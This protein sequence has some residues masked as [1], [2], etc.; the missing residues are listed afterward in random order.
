M[1][2]ASEKLAQLRRGLLEVAV[3]SVVSGGKV[4]A[5]DILVAL[6]RTE[7]ATGEGTL[8][9]LLSRLRREGLID[10]AWVESEAGPPRK[11]YSLT[12]SGR[13]QLDEM[14]AYWQGLNTTITRLGGAH[15]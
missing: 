2:E 8:Y 13:T 15:E 12:D 6:S 5:A 11:Y 14:K 3:L 7:F 4:Y 10:Y 9:P 1:N